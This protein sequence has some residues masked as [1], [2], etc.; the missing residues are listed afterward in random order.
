[1]KR[2]TSTADPTNTRRL[3]EEVAAVGMAFD[4][5]VEDANQTEASVSDGRTYG[6]SS[7]QQ[8]P[9]LELTGKWGLPLEEVIASMGT[10]MMLPS[11]AGDDEHAAI[12]WLEIRFACA[13]DDRP[14]ADIATEDRV[15]VAPHPDGYQVIILGTDIEFMVTHEEIKGQNF[16]CRA[17]LDREWEWWFGVEELEQRPREWAPN[18]LVLGLRAA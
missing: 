15:R 12:S 3:S 10:R 9:E 14:W 13:M 16:D 17:I 11:M 2:T 8:A 18:G 5:P 6:K 4:T 7:V 1:M